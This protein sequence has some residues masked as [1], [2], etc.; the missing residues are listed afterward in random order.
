MFV[1]Y[2]K[3]YVCTRASPTTRVRRGRMAAAR[4]AIVKMAPSGCGR[5]HLCK[6]YIMKTRSINLR[7]MIYFRLKRVMSFILCKTEIAGT[8]VNVYLYTLLKNVLP[9]KRQL[10]LL[11]QT[12]GFST[13]VICTYTQPSEYSS[14]KMPL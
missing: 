9:L 14:G 10:Q 3:M 12:C 7:R 2:F 5:A 1:F 11:M 8:R 13:K 6:H 4:I